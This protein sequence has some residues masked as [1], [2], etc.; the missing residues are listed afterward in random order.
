VSAPADALR[1]AAG[2]AGEGAFLIVLAGGA[3][4]GLPLRQ[5]REVVELAAVRAVP[6]RMPA[7]R[8]VMPLRDRF[9]SLVHLGALLGGGPAP[10]A[11]GDVAVVVELGRYSAALEVD[12]VAAVADR[13]AVRVGDAPMAW[14]TG[15]WQEGAD[16]VTVID[17][18]SLAE[19]IGGLGSGDDP[20]G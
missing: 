7:L 14:A 13:A 4:Y 20:A 5:V 3:R 12:A 8:G 11:H 17:L 15:I 19:R 6:S 2:A 1:Q 10:A 16:L 18:G 9:V